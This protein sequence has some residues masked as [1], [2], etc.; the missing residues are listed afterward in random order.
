M[1]QIVFAYLSPSVFH[2]Y[3]GASFVKL[4]VHVL[5]SL[6]VKFRL[7][8]VVLSESKQ[9]NDE[10]HRSVVSWVYKVDVGKK[11][12]KENHSLKICCRTFL[13]IGRRGLKLGF[14]LS[15]D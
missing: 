8:L 1:L 9:N 15:E 11:A 4:V 5:K 3:F 14:S 6:M 13:S 2:L 7:F 10:T 12:L